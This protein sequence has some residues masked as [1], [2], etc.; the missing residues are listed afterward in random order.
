MTERLD[1]LRVPL[2][3]N[4]EASVRDDPDTLLLRLLFCGETLERSLAEAALGSH[5]LKW[6]EGSGLLARTKEGFRSPFHLRYVRDLLL[7]S[8]YLGDEQDAVMGAGETTAILYQ[9]AR[10]SQRVG[11]TL[12]LGCGAG[13]LALLLAECSKFVIGTDI[14]ERAV[15]FGKF[16]AELNAVRNVEFRAGDT[17]EPVQGEKFDL[18][19]SQPP[20]Y[21]ASHGNGHQTF[22]H[23]GVRG[24]ELA[25]RVVEGVARHLT[26]TGRALIFTSWPEDRGPQPPRGFDSLELYS[27]RNEVSGTR[28]SLNVFQTVEPGRQE[29]AIQFAVSAECWGL[30]DSGRIDEL[31]ENETLLE[32]G[33]EALLASCLRLP[34]GAR[35]LHEAEQVLLQCPERELIG[36]VPIPHSHWLALKAVDAAATVGEAGADLTIVER[37][38]R[39]GL[40]RVKASA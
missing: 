16:N 26:Q 12:D 29:W 9:A 38:L 5:L 40:L 39:R 19:V 36:L 22:L 32:N 37:A 23:G 10:P 8:D 17:Y 33:R 34:P 3:P 27:N 25:N 31:F 20:Y 15:A 35:V 7:L 4:R 6:A 24:D 30:A 18:L 14:N 1:N 11:A 2:R 21:P 28:Q 13:T